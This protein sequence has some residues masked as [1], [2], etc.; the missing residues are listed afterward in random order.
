MSTETKSPEAP[1]E[2]NTIIPNDSLMHKAAGN[3]AFLMS[4][5]RCGEVLHA[6]EEAHV[7]EIIDAL[8]VADRRADTTADIVE[9]AKRAA[10]KIDK[11]TDD[12]E[13]PTREDY[14]DGIAAI[15][16][17]ELSTPTVPADDEGRAKLA[18]TERCGDCA[19]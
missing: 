10:E 2:A 11:Y 9:V 18:P 5:I 6:D 3:L 17:A 8:E 1:P 12:A 15:I 14:L 13:A 16:T 7:R 4:V 19:A